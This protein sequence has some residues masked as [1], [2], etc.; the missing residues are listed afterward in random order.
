MVNHTVYPPS[1]DGQA[2]IRHPRRPANSSCSRI[3]CLQTRNSVPCRPAV[4]PHENETMPDKTNR[5][6]LPVY[7]SV[8][9]RKVEMCK[10]VFLKN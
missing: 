3:I 1:E 5:S 7:D 2:L 6:V 8:G 9:I 4:P 10:A